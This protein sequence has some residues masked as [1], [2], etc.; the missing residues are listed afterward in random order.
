MSDETPRT[1]RGNTKQNKVRKMLDEDKVIRKTDQLA[2]SIIRVVTNKQQ[3][4]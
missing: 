1:A 3:Q 2:A 4:K